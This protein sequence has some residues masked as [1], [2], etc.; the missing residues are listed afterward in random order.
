MCGKYYYLAASLPYLRFGGKSLM[1]KDSFFEECRKW[2]GPGDIETVLGVDLKDPWI[3]HGDPPV[4]REWK[5]FDLEL[6]TALANTRKKNSLAVK[7]EI[8]WFLKDALAQKDPLS[9][10]KA[11]EKARWDFI[12]GEEYRYMFDMS[13]LVIYSLKIQI[14]ERLAAFEHEKGKR[15]FDKLCEVEDGQT[16]R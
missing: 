14:L 5:A 1:T 11:I 15:T 2:L 4:V 12:S 13:L 9:R 3:R 7:S 16:D 8:P 6:R 10:E